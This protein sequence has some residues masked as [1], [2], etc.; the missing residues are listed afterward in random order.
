MNN[1]QTPTIPQRQGPTSTS[2]TAAM[3]GHS[4]SGVVRILS[5]RTSLQAHEKAPKS[6]LVDTSRMLENS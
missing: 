4:R 5:F 3:S 6:V 1:Y 2:G